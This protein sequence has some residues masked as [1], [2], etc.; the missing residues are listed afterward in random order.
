M[1][2]C[3]SMNGPS[4]TSP[5]RF[6]HVFGRADDDLGLALLGQGVGHGLDDDLEAAGQFDVTQVEAAVGIL[7]Q[8]GINGP[9]REDGLVLEGPEGAVGTA[10]PICLSSEPRFSGEVG[11]MAAKA[12]LARRFCIVFYGATG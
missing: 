12:Q 6:S 8:V 2:L 10:T 4:V 7:E 11:P 5:L 1:P 3:F 9:G